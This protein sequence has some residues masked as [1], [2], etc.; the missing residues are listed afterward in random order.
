MTQPLTREE[1]RQRVVQACIDSLAHTADTARSEMESA[2]QQSNDYGANKDRYDAFR[3]KMM[4]ARDMYA[5]QL[6]G[7]QASLRVLD[8]LRRQP[9]HDVAEHGAVVQT[10]SACYFLSVG[11]GKVEV[12]LGCGPVACYAVSAQTPLFQAV[13]GL[14]VGDSFVL[15]G[16]MVEVLDIF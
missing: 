1:K 9:P 7:A 14:E 10:A 12:D 16:K 3:T 6:S 13:K 11:G 4:R 15:A 8:T 5:R 2:Q